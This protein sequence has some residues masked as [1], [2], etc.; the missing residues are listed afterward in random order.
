MRMSSHHLLIHTG[1]FGNNRIPRNERHCIYCN[2]HDL[3][4]EY[5]F[6]IICPCYNDLRRKYIKTYYYARP[7]VYKFLDLLNSTNKAL[8]TNLALYIKLA[9]SHR[10]TLTYN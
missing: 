9:S 5:H 2:L 3:E 6:I 10:A 4:D 8:I 7:S 1:R